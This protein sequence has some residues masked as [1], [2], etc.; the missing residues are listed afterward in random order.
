MEIGGFWIG[1]KCL[2]PTLYALSAYKTEKNV[3]KVEFHPISQSLFVCLPSA[4]LLF[5]THVPVIVVVTKIN[6]NNT[7]TQFGDLLYNHFPPLHQQRMW[8]SWEVGCGTFFSYFITM[9]RHAH[10]CFISKSIY[11][12]PKRKV[13]PPKLGK[14]V[15]IAGFW[16]GRKCLNPTLYALGA[17]K[18]AKKVEFHIPPNPY[19]FVYFLLSSFLTPTCQWLLTTNNT[20]THLWGLCYTQFSPC[21]RQNKGCGSW[22]AGCGRAF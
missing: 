13:C 2:K 9:V 6:T 22:E 10:F 4:V 15:E 19:S 5:D 20:L 17:Y 18:T 14:L 21:L 11:N 16:V 1:R 12:F 8:G 3:L 7:L